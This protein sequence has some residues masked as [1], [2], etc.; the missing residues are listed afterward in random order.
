MIKQYSGQFF[1][2]FWC[3]VRDAH[4]TST[5]PEKLSELMIKWI[6]SYL[7]P[8]AGAHSAPATGTGFNGERAA[9]TR[10]IRMVQDLS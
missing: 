2:K 9:E 1:W 6:N 4:A 10:L 5:L 3:G 8:V 7:V